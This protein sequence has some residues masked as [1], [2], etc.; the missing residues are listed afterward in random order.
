[1]VRPYVAE[2]YPLNLFGP[3]QQ[4]MGFKI[5]AI[6]T[7]ISLIYLFIKHYKKINCAEILILAAT[8]YMSL[9]HIRH[10]IFFVIAA[11]SYLYYYIYPAIDWLTFGITERFYSI[12]PTI[13][14]NIGKKIRDTIIYTLIILIGLLMILIAPRNINLEENQCRRKQLNSS[15]RIIYQETCWYYSTGEAMRSGNYIHKTKLP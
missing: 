13:F 15:N 12:F 2:W 11:S 3:I 10:I 7:V 9:Q 4:V 5:F 1:M 14:R 6:L 8:F